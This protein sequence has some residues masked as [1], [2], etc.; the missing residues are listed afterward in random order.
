ME[1]SKAPI[2]KTLEKALKKI[3]WP[4]PLAYT[5]LAYSPWSWV[6]SDLSQFLVLDFFNAQIE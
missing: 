4:Y 1:L 3:W 2:K 6:H 5:F